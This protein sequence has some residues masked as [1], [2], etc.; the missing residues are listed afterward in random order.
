L[1]KIFDIADEYVNKIAALSPLTATHLG[2]PGQDDKMTDYSPTGNE[3]SADLDRQTLSELESAEPESEQDRIAREAM[4]EEIRLSLDIHDAGESLRRLSVIHSPIHSIRMIFDLMPR[5]TE[6]HWSNIAA[7]LNLVSQ[8]L[9]SFRHTLDEGIFQ[10]KVVSKRQAV[11]TAGQCLVWNGSAEGQTSFFEGLLDIYDEAG[12]GSDAQRRQIESGAQ[13]ANRAM[14]EMAAYLRETYTPHA[15]EKNAVGPERYALA[16]RTF[17]GVDLDL[18]E[19]YRWGWEQLHW[20]NEE[21]SKT[22]ERILPGGSVEEAENLLE[23][24][25]GRSIEGEEAFKE[26]MQD[27]QDRTIDELNGTHFDIAKPVKKIEALIAPPGGALAM[28]YTPPSEDFSRPGRTWYPTGGKTVFP[29]WGEVSIAYHEGVPGHHFQLATTTHLSSQLSRYQRLLGGTSGYVEGWAL[30]AER[31]M[32]ELGYL[33]NP[34]YYLGMLRAQALRSVR[35]II[36]IGMHLELQIPSDESFHPGE[37]WTPE[38]GQEF[39]NLNRHGFPVA[40]MASEISRYLGLPGQ[41]ISYKVGERAWRDARE[42]V[43]DRQGA[44][45]D[46]KDFHTRALSL[47][48]MGLAQMRRELTRL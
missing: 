1:S 46:L 7:R 42:E 45:F 17:N 28:Y 14:D 39:I 48:P 32:A 36:D 31:L 10:G 8:G 20:V 47:G 27:L 25:P 12:I 30:Y 15:A 11:E 33:E 6:E 38:L 16:S 40:F 43:K 21:M 22:A 5:E 24:D 13:A 34:D 26:W 44:E 4:M 23:T 29:I 3:A 35:V 2:I 37:T 18:S 19:T 41:A 9:E